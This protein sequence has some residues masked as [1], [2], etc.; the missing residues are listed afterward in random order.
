MLRGNSTTK[1]RSLE[2][3]NANKGLVQIFEAKD[4]GHVL[5][6]DKIGDANGIQYAILG[7]GNEYE[8]IA[9]IK[10]TGATIILPINFPEAYDVTNPY[11]AAMVALKDMRHWNQAPSNPKVLSDNGVV[12]SFTLYDLKSPAKFK[13]K[14]MKAIQY[15]LSETKALEALTTVPAAILGKSGSIGTLQVGRQANFL[16]TSGAIFDKETILYENW[17]QGNKNIIADKNLKDIRGKYDLSAGGITYKMAITGK[18]NK[19]K[20]EIKQD[21]NK[22]KSKLSY[23]DNWI[24]LSFATDKGDNNY[25]MTGLVSKASD[26]IKGRLILPNGTESTFCSPKNK[27][28]YSG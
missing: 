18:A 13:E 9:D 16:I 15:G 3:L 5:R 19:P 27:W 11:E 23:K 17:V 24:N 25:R 6:A 7:G 20:I 21:T 10:A 12:F 2:A 14:L 22:L 1:D 26:N 28:I 4:K 8:R